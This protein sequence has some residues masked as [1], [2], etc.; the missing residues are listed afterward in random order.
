M[1]RFRGS[2]PAS[3]DEKGRLKVPSVFRAQIEEAFGP[4]LF[5][6]SI[7][8]KNV[9]LY[10][11]A[12]WRALEEKL[13]AL[14]SVHRPKNKFLER[15]N[16]YGQDASLDGQGRVLIPQILRDSAKLPPEVVVTGNIDHLIVSDR[17]ALSSRLA[18]EDFT[19]EDYDELSK[20][21][22]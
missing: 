14:P 8:G 6:T 2:A 12:M 13:A 20:A 9:L 4:E 11:L 5:V 19:P 17:G 3:V 16:Y 7:S 22:S 15:V 21:L 10:P 18:T 1:D